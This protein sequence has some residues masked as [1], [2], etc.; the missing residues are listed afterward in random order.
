MDN[1]GR[2][3]RLRWD[4]LLVVLCHQLLEQD[5]FVRGVLVDEIQPIGAFRDEIGLTDLADETH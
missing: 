5:A 2:E 4:L 1:D 3:Q